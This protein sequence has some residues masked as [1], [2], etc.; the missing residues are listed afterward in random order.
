MRSPRTVTRLFARIKQQPPLAKIGDETAAA[1]ERVAGLPPFIW[2]LTAETLRRGVEFIH[3]VHAH[4]WTEV[5]KLYREYPPASSE[6][7]LHPEKW[8]SREEPVAIAW[9]AFEQDPRWAARSSW[10]RTCSESFSGAWCSGRTAL[11]LMRHRCR[12]DGAGPLAVLRSRTNGKVLLLMYT[13]WD[14]DE[15][16]REFANAYRH[17]LAAKY[18]TEPTPTR[19]LEKVTPSPRSPG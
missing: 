14:T 4:G 9:P 16:A 18:T 2:D 15:D 12:L 17:V 10:V 8:F 13:S 7:V 6:Q 11:R 5:E 1:L 3:A 19:M